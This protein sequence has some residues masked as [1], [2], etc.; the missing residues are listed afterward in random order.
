MGAGTMGT[1]PASNV[2][3]HVGAPGSAVASETAALLNESLGSGFTQPSALAQL[4]ADGGGVLIRARG[5][6]GGL[7]GAATAR[8]LDQ[9]SQAVLR[10]RLRITGVDAGLDGRRVGELKSIVV[11]PAARGTGIGSIMLAASLDFLKARGCHEVVSASWV[12][13]DPRHS[14][15]G[16]LERAG[17][18]QVATIAAFW[19][20]DQQA[21]G[22]LCP[23]CGDGCVCAAVILVLPLEGRDSRR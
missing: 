12:S 18:A 10:D 7:L 23:L 9:G 3:L 14:S 5:R 16:M 4:T 15:L 20:D 19:A 2:S 1:R 21:A 11:G 13:A 6:G 8:V 22:Y 17:F